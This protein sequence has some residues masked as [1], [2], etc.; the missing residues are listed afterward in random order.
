MPERAISSAAQAL[1]PGG[2]AF[3]MQLAIAYALGIR[4]APLQMLGAMSAAGVI[5]AGVALFFAEVV[6]LSPVFAG[7]LGG[8]SGIVPVVVAA[9][10]ILKWVSKRIGVDLGDITELLNTM[11]AQMQGRAPESAAPAG[12]AAAPAPAH[13]APE[14]EAS[15][16]TP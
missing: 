1:W 8:A 15:H 10:L 9:F 13:P 11:R 6:H 5:G 16:G 4:L 2:L 12:Q 14:E 7:M 3:L